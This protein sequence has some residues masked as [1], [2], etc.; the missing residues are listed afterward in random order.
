MKLR[1]AMN[2]LYSASV[3][4]GSRTWRGFR[5]TW[6]GRGKAGKGA[7][8]EELTERAYAITEED[9]PGLVEL[10]AW[11]APEDPPPTLTGLVRHHEVKPRDARLPARRLIVWLPPGYD[12]P[13]DTRR[14]PV[15]YMHDGQ[16]LMDALTAFARVE[17]NVDETAEA[18]VR[19]GRVEPVIIVGIYNTGMDRL[20]EY[21]HTA[22]E[23]YPDAG[24]ADLYG[25]FLVNELKPFID[26][27][28]RTRPEGACTGLAGSSLGGL[29]SLYLGMKYPDTFT[30]L[31]VISPSV[32][33]DERDILGRVAALSGPLP[34]RIWV[35]MG[36]QEG[37]HEEAETVEDAARLH[38][39]L[40][41]KGWPED[42]VR[43]TVYEGAE[44]TE[45]AWS[46][47]FAEVLEYLYP[48]RGGSMRAATSGE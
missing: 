13:G 15:L 44:H 23:K 20:P 19:A 12:T 25:D 46:A 29:V 14:Y 21:T 40:L 36:T 30:R 48:A 32:W 45:A 34:L 33:W 3:S 26:R 17:W 35:D 1:T 42:D 27:A 22:T 18:L 5:A 9:E 8:G 31:G 47:R 10:A 41:E 16:N 39:A 11:R 4:L 24:R 6:R 38:Q 43:Y 37:D 28:Y 2:S 7:M